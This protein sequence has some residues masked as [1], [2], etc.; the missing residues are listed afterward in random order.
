MFSFFLC[1][2]CFFDQNAHLRPIMGRFYIPTLGAKCAM[3]DLFW[4]L[5]FRP[6]DFFAE[7]R[8]RITFKSL[9]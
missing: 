7:I 5:K 2:E 4:S 6:F 3:V 8:S 1:G 9:L